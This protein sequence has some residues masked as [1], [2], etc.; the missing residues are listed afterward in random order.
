M[1]DFTDNIHINGVVIFMKYR[2]NLFDMQG[3]IR[4]IFMNEGNM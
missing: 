4:D 1:C 2:L 3:R